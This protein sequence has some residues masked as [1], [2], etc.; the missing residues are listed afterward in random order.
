MPVSS[1]VETTGLAWGIR[2]S[3]RRYVQRVAHGTEIPDGG[4]GSL[5]D[6]RF[7]FPVEAVERFDPEA[8]DAQIRF[9][10]A[11]RFL[12]H[13]G[14]IDVRLGELELRCSAGTGTVLTGA[15]GGARELVD[16]QVTQAGV[17]DGVATLL[18]GTRLAADAVELFDEVYAAATPFD[19]IE[20]RV[21]V[22]S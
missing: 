2:S 10:G 20:V 18:L 11:V 13:A 19:E 21:A 1:T 4:A 6:G 22:A 5:P 9:A 17:A 12:G 14:M 8:L 7:Y 16:V 3:F 15:R